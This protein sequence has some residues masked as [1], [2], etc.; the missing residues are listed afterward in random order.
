MKVVQVID[1]LHLAGAQIMCGHLSVEL[2]KSGSDVVVI[3][4][5]SMHSA[6]SELLNENGIKVIYLNKKP[7]VDFSIIGKL[8]KALREEAPDVIHTHIG[9]FVYCAL[10]A[11]GLK[12]KRW[13]HTVHTL[14]QREA[15]GIRGVVEKICFRRRK[16]IPVA[17]SSVVQKTIAEKYK[18]EPTDIPIAFNGIDLSRCIPKKNYLIHDKFTIIHIGRFCKVKNHTGLIRAFDLFHSK[19]PDSQLCLIGRGEL[20]QEVK[21]YVEKLGIT[22]SVQFLDPQDNVYPFLN[23]SDVFTLPSFAEGIPMTII[24]AMGT[25]LPIVATAVG[26]V[27]DMLENNVNALLCEVDAEKLAECFEKYYLDEKL[28][29][30]HGKAALERS[31]AFSAEE[32]AEKYLNIYLKMFD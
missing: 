26:G 12:G 20:E 1:R 17:L 9:V 24:E 11:V 2:K 29:E 25:G 31:K 30:C 19:Y 32:M 22:N 10:S 23:Q 18:L 8:K 3:S 28:R 7:G 4:L 27:P 14:A 13:I 21:A 15:P 6:I 5:Y 16:A